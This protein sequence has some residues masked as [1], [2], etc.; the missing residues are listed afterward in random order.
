[1]TSFLSSI[2]NWI[3][4]KPEVPDLPPNIFFEKD[5]TPSNDFWVKFWCSYFQNTLPKLPRHTW[6]QNKW[7]QYNQDS[8]LEGKGLNSYFQLNIPVIYT[9][10]LSSVLRRADLVK[11]VMPIDNIDFVVNNVLRIHFNAHSFWFRSA[12]W[13]NIV[14]CKLELMYNLCWWTKILYS[15]QLI[16]NCREFGSIGLRC[17]VYM[18]LLICMDFLNECLNIYLL[19]FTLYNTYVE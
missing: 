19:K 16:F 3:V 6:S 2:W 7:N 9:F 5:V 14:Q 4:E 8:R 13:V 11:L 1:M 17:V 10:L 18:C 15:D 12:L